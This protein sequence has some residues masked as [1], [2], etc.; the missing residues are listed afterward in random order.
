MQDLAA[1]QKAVAETRATS[2]FLEGVPISDTSLEE[3]L[4]KIRELRSRSIAASG[5][6]L[7]LADGLGKLGPTAEEVRKLDEQTKKL[8]ETLAKNAEWAQ[9]NGAALV[10][11]GS[12]ARN[13]AQMMNF[14]DARLMLGEVED[15][16]RI[17][18]VSVD[19]FD[20]SARKGAE[21][22]AQ[23]AGEARL[24]AAE[25]L[26]KTGPSL[27]RMTVDIERAGAAAEKSTGLF[28]R[29]TQ[30]LGD[31]W[32]GMSGGNG[33]KGLFENLGDSLITGFGNLLSGGITSMV[34]MA[35]EGLG[36]LAGK[37]WHSLT[38]GPSEAEVQ[39]RKTAADFT[40]GLEEELTSG[41]LA[42]VAGLVAEG[43][44]RNWAIQAV[45]IQ[46][47]FIAA[48]K[49]A[50][51]ALVWVDRLWQ[52]EKQGPEAV[53]AVMADLEPILDKHRE[54]LEANAEAAKKAAGELSGMTEPFD[55]LQEKIE[56]LESI[57][58]IEEAFEDFRKSGTLDLRT[59]LREVERL[60]TSL[61]DNAALMDLSEAIKQAVETGIVDFNRLRGCWGDL[62]AM[63]RQG[64][65]IPLSFESS[66]GGGD[67]GGGGDNEG[68]DRGGYLTP[69]EARE[70]GVQWRPKDDFDWSDSAY[71]DRRDQDASEINKQAEENSFAGGT[72]GRY[73]NFGSGTYATLH[74]SERV[75]TAAEGAAESASYAE[76]C[77]IRR[78]LQDLPRALV[79]PYK[80]ALIEAG[81]RY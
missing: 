27:Q 31:L 55:I 58:E 18:G 34:N 30:G 56:N 45:A 41:Q 46:D 62:E 72:G 29:F 49:T 61:G 65:T 59:V 36:K 6:V 44:S 21:G 63:M 10:K 64:V 50:E 79:M 28:A 57:N 69:E 67:D 80:T 38:G 66:G 53:A 8:K 20:L 70:A 16:I 3:Q 37:L 26:A 25:I 23:L 76:L 52:A 4:E 9:R 77:A 42:T 5:A 40:R 71:R 14:N 1:A 24:I 15:A 75:M 19:E 73:L 22:A 47:A 35:I 11:M 39:G 43:A 17:A 32:K 51:E 12:D 60:Q 2:G 48:G 13:A 81:Y 7:Q 54:Q 78:L 74:G 68:G 33:F